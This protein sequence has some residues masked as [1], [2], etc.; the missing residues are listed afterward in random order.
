MA[1]LITGGI[2]GT[3]GEYSVGGNTRLILF[4]KDDLDESS[5]VYDNAGSDVNAVTDF[6]L[7]AGKVAY[8]IQAITDS[9]GTSMDLQNGDNPS[10]SKFFLQTTTFNVAGAYQEVFNF[11]KDLGLA[12]VIALI[13][14]KTPATLPLVG[15]KWIIAGFTTG[16]KA[17][18]ITGGTGTG[19]NDLAGFQITL[20]DGFTRPLVEF[21]NSDIA[22]FAAALLV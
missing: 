20:S 15:N 9:V 10:S 13:E 16:L 21:K 6:D 5:I 2:A 18:A 17:T 4:N 22:A 3:C 7:K 14:T 19:I 8:E 12:K 1:C 11:I